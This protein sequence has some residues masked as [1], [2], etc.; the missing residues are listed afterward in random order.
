LSVSDV[1]NGSSTVRSW[2]YIADMGT[3]AAEPHPD[4]AAPIG[5]ASTNRLLVEVYLRHQDGRWNAVAPDYTVVGVGDTRQQALDSML[6][7]LEDYLVLCAE[8]GVAPRDARRPISRAWKLELQ[9]ELMV[10]AMGGA[11]RRLVPKKLLGP[12]SEV[13]RRVPERP[14]HLEVPLDERLIA[15]Y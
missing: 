5:A 12:M 9:L 15:H 1:Q 13:R 3:M 7:M 2:Q 11:V 6:E 4:K 10:G 8:D 14:K